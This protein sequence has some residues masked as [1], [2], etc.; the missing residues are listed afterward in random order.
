M[1]EDLH[2]G[3]AGGRDGRD[4]RERGEMWARLTRGGKGRKICSG[5]VDMCSV[6][7]FMCGG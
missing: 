1:V 2:D 3:Y 4:G 7:L 5:S 6:F